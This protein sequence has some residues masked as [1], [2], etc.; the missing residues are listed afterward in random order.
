MPGVARVQGY[1]HSR[2]GTYP[3]PHVSRL[4]VPTAYVGHGNGPTSPMA[5]NEFKTGV[6]IM[7]AIA[8]IMRAIPTV[9][10]CSS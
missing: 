3:H 9:P 2:K 1:Y 5:G 7:I 6:V 4:A 10:G 8:F